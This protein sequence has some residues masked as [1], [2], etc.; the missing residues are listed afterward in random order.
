MTLAEDARSI[1]KRVKKKKEKKKKEKE[2]RESLSIV[3]P[4]TKA[5]EAD[6][7]TDYYDRMF[8]K[9][10]FRE[11]MFNSNWTRRRTVATA[12]TRKEWS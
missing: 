10:Y 4:F 8:R 3:G 9:K 12:K 7:P 11:S 6:P 1:R 2:K 5:S